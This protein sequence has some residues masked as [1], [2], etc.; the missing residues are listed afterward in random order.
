MF[1]LV[2]PHVSGASCLHLQGI[3]YFCINLACYQDFIV[4]CMALAQEFIY[5]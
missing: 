4:T 1:S 3:N 5:S 2:M